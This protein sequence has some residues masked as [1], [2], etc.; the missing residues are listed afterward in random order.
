M[1]LCE[2]VLQKFYSAKMKTIREKLYSINTGRKDCYYKDGIN[3]YIVHG[4]N[5]VNPLQSGT[6]AAVHFF[7]TIDAGKSETFRL[8]IEFGTLENL[9]RNLKTYFNKPNRGSGSVL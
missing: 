7:K 2:T 4:S 9:S 8:R 3:E 6:K 1:A 5:T